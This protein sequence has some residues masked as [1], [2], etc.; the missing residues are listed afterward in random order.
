MNLGLQV[1]R[2]VH[3]F[4]DTNMHTCIRMRIPAYR[5]EDSDDTQWHHPQEEE[6]KDQM[7]SVALNLDEQSEQ[8]AIIDRLTP[9]SSKKLRPDK[10]AK[11]PSG[12]I[13][14]GV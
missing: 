9:K 13:F 10:K 12:I 6:F 2:Q 5:H 4:K 11:S 8:Q 1:T 7:R 3:V 14:Q